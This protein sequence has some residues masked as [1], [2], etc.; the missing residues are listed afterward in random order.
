MRA[1]SGGR[2]GGGGASR[3]AVHGEAR[4]TGSERGEGGEETRWKK[5]TSSPRR[6][7]SVC[8]GFFLRG[9]CRRQSLTWWARMVPGWVES[10]GQGL[11][12]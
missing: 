10:I 12:V 6:R 11:W 2:R 5:A 3:G 1:R 9:G 8:E 4:A 7:R